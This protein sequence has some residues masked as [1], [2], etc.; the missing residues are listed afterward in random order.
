MPNDEDDDPDP[1]LDWELPVEIP[2]LDDAPQYEPDI[3]DFWSR[4]PEI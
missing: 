3:E 4:L 1:I 2:I